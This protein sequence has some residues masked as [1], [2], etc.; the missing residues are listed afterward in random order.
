MLR[1]LYIPSYVFE[2]VLDRLA[3]RENVFQAKLWWRERTISIHHELSRVAFTRPGK[4]RVNHARANAFVMIISFTSSLDYTQAGHIP[5][6]WLVV[7]R[8]KNWPSEIHG[9]MIFFLNN[10]KKKPRKFFC[11]REWADVIFSFV[12]GGCV[13]YTSHP[14]CSLETQLT[15][16]RK[17]ARGNII[18]RPTGC[19]EWGWVKMHCVRTDTNTHT[20]VKKCEREKCREFDVASLFLSVSMAFDWTSFR[21]HQFCWWD[22]YFCLCSTCYSLS[23]SLFPSGENYKWHIKKKG[24]NYFYVGI[25]EKHCVR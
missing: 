22:C 8:K 1:I 9:S 11:P 6:T 20:H 10:K 23:L 13:F 12:C 2:W 19:V 24:K 16:R 3:A 17:R 25:I 18:E 15:V 7:S 5:K 21:C 4:H 14:S